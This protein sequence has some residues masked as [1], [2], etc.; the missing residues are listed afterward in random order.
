MIRFMY[1]VHVA[2]RGPAAASDRQAA[3]LGP[4][5]EADRRL[6]LGAFPFENPITHPVFDDECHRKG[7]AAARWSHHVA[8]ESYTADRWAR[9]GL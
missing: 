9:K 8:I 6:L 3:A 7:A 1:Y 5:L 4:A 2:P